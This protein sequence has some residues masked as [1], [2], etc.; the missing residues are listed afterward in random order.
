MA[1]RSVTRQFTVTW[2]LRQSSQSTAKSLS[3][4]AAHNRDSV[5]ACDIS[6]LISGV[7]NPY[8]LTLICLNDVC[9]PLSRQ[10]ETPESRE[11]LMECGERHSFLLP[12]TRVSTRWLFSALVALACIASLRNGQKL[13]GLLCL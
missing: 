7:P 4:F 1:P 2:L 13:K 9:K 6:Q 12:A 5:S 8:L 11:N 10:S 3:K